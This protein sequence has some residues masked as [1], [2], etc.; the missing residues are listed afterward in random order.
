MMNPEIEEPKPAVDSFELPCGYL[1]S[2]GTLHT[3][4]EVREM[5]GEEEEYLGAKNMPIQKKINR[6]LSRCTTSIGEYRG[7]SSIEKMM[8]EL[9]QGDRMYLLFAIR[10]VTLGNDMPFITAC[11]QCEQESNVTIDLSD[12]TIIKMPD[13]RVRTYEVTLPK[14]G[15]VVRM[16]VMNGRGEE[17]L[18]KA[19]Q[20]GKDIISH[21]ILARIDTFDNRPATLADMKAL[22]LA[23]RNFLRNAW[24]GREGGVDTEVDV[25][26]PHCDNE[27]KT[28]IDLGSQ[29]FFNPLAASRTWKKRSSS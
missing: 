5:T 22:S 3:S 27:Y 12:L 2:D 6:I 14:A 10:R 11:P 7:E 28:N 25:Q 15:K 26:C 17:A 1:D 16:K 20:A 4:V 18:N 29:G 9:T 19:A 23:D 8:P 13:P 24:E 21:A